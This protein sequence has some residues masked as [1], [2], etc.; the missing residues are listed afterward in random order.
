[1]APFEILLYN[2]VCIAMDY[3]QWT[4]GYYDAV[5]CGGVSLPPVSPVEVVKDP[6]PSNNERK[7]G[8]LLTSISPPLQWSVL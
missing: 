1:M 2:T 8:E 4:V 7:P 6:G 3:G 5:W